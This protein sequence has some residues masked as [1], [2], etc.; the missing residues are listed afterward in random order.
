MRS[1]SDTVNKTVKKKGLTLKGRR[2][3]Y[4]YL[5]LLP[6]IVGFI[7]F[8]LYPLIFSVRLGFNEV[9]L[10]PNG[11]KMIW[12]G[13]HYYDLAW[14]VDTTFKLN[15]TDTI[16]SILCSTPVVLVFSLII[17]LLLNNKYPLRTFF[18]TVFFFPVVI[19]SGPAISELLTAH[20]LDFSERA[21]AVFEFIDILPDILK[22][23]TLYVLN[24]LVLI[25]WFSGVQILIFLAGLQKISPD[26][27][28]AAEIDGA[29]AWEKFWK[30]T[31]PYISPMMLLC[32]IYTVIDISNYAN[33]K[34]NM[35][36]SNNI[37]SSSGLYSF[38]AAMSWIYF[39]AVMLILA[40]VYL[41]GM[42]FTRRSR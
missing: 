11:M 30:I 21:P 19:M 10:D 2:A 26:I 8:T 15:L 17:A 22:E 37:I 14:N 36:I 16:T 40:G 27:Y 23:P 33:N 13:G 9:H 35:Q 28:S 4:G 25:L 20:S 38:S 29:G 39:G 34:V 18:R 3:I 5:F 24:N 31:L 32:A 7:A 41:I 12:Q 42:L 6:W 1:R